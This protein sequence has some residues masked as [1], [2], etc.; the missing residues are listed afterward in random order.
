MG[1]SPASQ[2]TEVESRA[3]VLTD[4]EKGK[5]SL[6]VKRGLSN[7]FSTPGTRLRIMR[8]IS[9]KL[10]SSGRGIWQKLVSPG[11]T[12]EVAR[13]LETGYLLNKTLLPTHGTGDFRELSARL[14]PLGK[15]AKRPVTPDKSNTINSPDVFSKGFRLM[16]E[17]GHLQGILDDFG[18][19]PTPVNYH[20]LDTA[21]VRPR[22]ALPGTTD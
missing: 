21:P 15:T 8:H 1:F 13:W 7:P 16:V 18:H 4:K 20:G 17:V 12:L 10:N 19:S 14:K 3:A 6:S 9:Q 11:S 2:A 5:A 22:Y